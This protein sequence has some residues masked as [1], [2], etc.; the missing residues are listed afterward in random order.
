MARSL[1]RSYF[2][3]MFTIL[4]AA[5]GVALGFLLEA[6]LS[7]LL[8]NQQLPSWSIG[9]LIGV[10]LALAVGLPHYLGIRRD[11]A[12]DPSAAH[13][14]VRSVT[15]NVTQAIAALIA[16]FGGALAIMVITPPSPSRALF[17]SFLP[18]AVAALAV[19]WIVQFVRGQAQPTAGA[20][21]VVQRLFLY[22]TQT[23][24]VFIV[25]YFL[26]PD[27][28]VGEAS[29]GWHQPSH[30]I[31]SGAAPYSL[32]VLLGVLWGVG[33]WLVYVW[34]ARNEAGSRLRLVAQYLGLGLGLGCLVVG[35]RRLIFVAIALAFNNC[36]SL[37]SVDGDCLQGTLNIGPG[38]VIAP[39]LVF[40]LLLVGYGVW[41]ALEAG[42]NR[43][44]I[45][46]TILLGVALAAVVFGW[47]LYVGLARILIGIAVRVTTS[48]DFNAWLFSG[49]SLLGAGLLHLLWPYILR[50]RGIAGKTALGPRQAYLLVGLAAGLLF[51][52]IY[53]VSALSGL[54]HGVGPSLG[55]LLGNIPRALN[56]F[57]TTLTSCPSKGKCPPPSVPPLYVAGISIL[58]GLYIALIHYVRA[59]RE[60]VFQPGPAKPPEVTA[61]SILE[62]LRSGRI[63]REEALAQLET[64]VD[65]AE[66]AAKP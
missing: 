19:F 20:S 56:A 41:L 52:I 51:V 43:L 44:G 26:V 14:L 42:Q 31:G 5:F 17:V 40:L 28:I 18:P 36:P 21:L 1:V 39:L 65:A 54:G 50:R 22:G 37:S 2:Y 34:L 63:T 3:V 35:F 11:L 57:W 23:A 16:F 12:E 53:G 46:D 13:S 10:L 60:Q 9:S 66:P 48:G 55:T 15:L 61:H 8:L 45:R 29:N 7:A 33:T 58:V 27:L 47:A 30:L 32:G 64:L 24:I 62:H 4:V 6:V 38:D 59:R 25:V 49:F